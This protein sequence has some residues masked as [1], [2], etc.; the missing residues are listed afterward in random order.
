M[1]ENKGSLGGITYKDKVIQVRNRTLSNPIKAYNTLTKKIEDVEV[2]NGEIGYTKVHG[3]DHKKW[4][5]PQ[6]Y[7]RQFQVIFSRKHHLW[8]PYNSDSRVEENLELAYAI[9]VHKSQ[10]SEYPAVIIPILIQHYML[11]QRNLIYTAVT[12]GKKLVILVGTR[13]A[14][15]IGIRND[16]TLKRYTLLEKRLSVASPGRLSAKT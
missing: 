7:L 5:W 16:K 6:F 9:S 8:A 13:K 15:A 2:F 4:T 1:L 14:L 3:Y 12:R 10:G 11:L